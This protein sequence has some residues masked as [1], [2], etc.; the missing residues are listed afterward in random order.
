MFNGSV[1]RKVM[2]IVGILGET[3]GKPADAI[4]EKAISATQHQ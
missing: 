2:M 1:Q 4:R 3:S